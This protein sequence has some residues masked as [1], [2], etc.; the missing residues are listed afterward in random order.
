MTVTSKRL[1]LPSRDWASVDTRVATDE[2]GNAAESH[3]AQQDEAAEED[4]GLAQLQEGEEVHPLILGLLQ[5]GVDL[6]GKVYDV[7]ITND[8]RYNSKHLANLTT[9]VSCLK[10]SYPAIVP[11][12]AA[13]T[14]HVAQHSPN[15]PRHA[16]V[17]PHDQAVRVC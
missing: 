16:C 1:T 7:G 10:G 2:A 17:C 5:Q 6:N 4:A 15:H 12:H 11:L 13:Q 8:M 9:S 14:A 3:L